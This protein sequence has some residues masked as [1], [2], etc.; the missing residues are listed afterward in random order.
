MGFQPDHKSGHITVPWLGLLGKRNVN[1]VDELSTPKESEAFPG[2]WFQQVAAQVSLLLGV[3]RADLRSL[4]GAWA[5]LPLRR[6]HLQPGSPGATW[7][8][9]A[10]TC[11]T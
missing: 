3:T 7:S 8:G 4:D 5:H 10:P 11:P 9:S 6:L 2:S 1:S